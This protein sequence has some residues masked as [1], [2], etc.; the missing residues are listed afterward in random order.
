[1]T[2]LPNKQLLG[3]LYDTPSPATVELPCP[4][5]R[6]RELVPGAKYDPKCIDAIRDLLTYFVPVE[7]ADAIIDMAELW[8]WIAVS[9]NSYMSAYSALEAPDGNAQWCY[10]V[11]PEIPPVMHKATPVPTSVRMVKFFIKAYESSL[12][13]DSKACMSCSGYESWFE[14]SIYRKNGGNSYECQNDWYASMAAPHPKYVSYIRDTEFPGSPVDNPLDDLVRWPVA[15]CAASDSGAWQE[16][17]WRSDNAGRGS[18]FV[19]MLSVGDQIVL[20]AKTKLPGWID[21]I[22]NVKMEIFYAFSSSY[23]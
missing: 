15:N 14:T 2:C 3:S 10:L 19:N 17:V 8:P 21:T 18:D 6:D 4:A 20:M 1:M 5:D 7:L 16:I 12:A 9:R 11:S 23:L 13:G 22:F